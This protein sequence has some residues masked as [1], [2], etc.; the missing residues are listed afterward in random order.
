MTFKLRRS[1]IDPIHVFIM[2][3]EQSMKYTN[4]NEFHN[5]GSH[6]F[7]RVKLYFFIN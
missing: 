5:Q 3:Q 2:T 1:V 4:Y 7:W 6:D